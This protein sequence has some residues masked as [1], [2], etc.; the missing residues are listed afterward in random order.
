MSEFKPT[1]ESIQEILAKIRTFVGREEFEWCCGSLGFEIPEADPAFEPTEARIQELVDLWGHCTRLGLA[2]ERRMTAA[3]FR[4]CQKSLTL[5]TTTLSVKPDTDS[6]FAPIGEPTTKAW[7]LD[8]PVELIELLEAPKTAE[9]PPALEIILSYYHGTEGG[10]MD[11]RSLSDEIIV[12]VL[13]WLLQDYDPRE[14]NARASIEAMTSALLLE[15]KRR[16]WPEGWW[17]DPSVILGWIDDPD[18]MKA[19]AVNRI[20]L[21]AGTRV[22]FGTFSDE[23]LVSMNLWVSLD[24]TPK[25]KEADYGSIQQLMGAIHAEGERRGWP[26]GWYED[27]SRIPGMEEAEEHP[28]IAGGPKSGR[29]CV[30]G[31]GD[32]YVP[33]RDPDDEDPPEYP[34]K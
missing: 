1:D 14:D 10:W 17:E 28:K 29:F 22:D 30:S 9:S 20:P 33:P 7:T 24:Y 2:P 6:P 31:P 13:M 5:A 21:K 34:I 16:G 4:W 23:L 18:P 12:T 19:I 8:L 26:E 27:P 25:T 11:L 15:G 32:D 3:E